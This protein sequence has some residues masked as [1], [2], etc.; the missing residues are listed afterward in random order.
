MVSTDGSADDLVECTVVKVPIDH[1]IWIRMHSPFAE[2][3]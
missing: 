3:H 1:F 2:K